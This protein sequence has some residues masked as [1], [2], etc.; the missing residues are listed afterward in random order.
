[1]GRGAE[2]ACFAPADAARRAKA[3][4]R[5]WSAGAAAGDRKDPWHAIRSRCTFVSKAFSETPMR[6]SGLVACAATLLA[7]STSV[8]AADGLSPSVKTTIV[9]SLLRATIALAD[10]TV[11]VPLEAGGRPVTL[12][13]TPHSLRAP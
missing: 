3:G 6:Q 2:M 10:R 12:R 5:T 4:S 9:P 13:L 7:V 8:F 1:M 11:D